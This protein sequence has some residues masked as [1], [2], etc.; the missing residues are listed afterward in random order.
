M[1]NQAILRLPKAQKGLKWGKT[2][3]SSDAQHG[4]RIIDD[5]FLVLIIIAECKN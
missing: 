4:S 3:K 1:V 5:E 2:F